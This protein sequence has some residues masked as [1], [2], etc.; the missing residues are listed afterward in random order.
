VE[1]RKVTVTSLQATNLCP[2]STGEVDTEIQQHVA[3]GDA[4]WWI[5]RHAKT[6]HEFNQVFVSRQIKGRQRLHH[7]QDEAQ[8]VWTRLHGRHH[9]RS[10]RPQV[11]I[12]GLVLSA[13]DRLVWMSR[14][15]PV[16]HD[17]G[18]STPLQVSCLR[19]GG[20]VIKVTPGVARLFASENVGC[21][22]AGESAH[23]APDS[24]VTPLV[25]L[26]ALEGIENVCVAVLRVPAL[27]SGLED[28]L[29]LPAMV[30]AFRAV[31]VR[32][33]RVSADDAR[34]EVG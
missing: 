28:V 19:R 6:A 3:D 10:P 32:P 8:V 24:K 27:F 31:Q 18:M 23:A 14:L 11:P 30:D 4:G 20:K 2:Q 34:K 1:E 21:R 5:M 9:A 12:D 33:G 7:E 17:G 26:V 25:L 16:D 22:V 29:R 13:S 15:A